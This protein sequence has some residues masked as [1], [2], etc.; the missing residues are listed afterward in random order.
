M[1]KEYPSASLLLVQCPRVWP[2]LLHFLVHEGINIQ[3]ATSLLPFL[4]VSTKAYTW[5]IA[6]NTRMM[7]GTKEIK[8]KD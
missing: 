8:S 7:E 3:V 5:S 1:Q 4:E 6:I 2:L